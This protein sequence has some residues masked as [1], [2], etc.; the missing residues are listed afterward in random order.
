MEHSETSLILDCCS[1]LRSNRIHMMKK[2]ATCNGSFEI[3]QL[4]H[5]TEALLLPTQQ[6]PPHDL[7]DTGRR[8]A[9]QGIEHAD[10]FI[11]YSS[12]VN[13]GASGRAAAS[14]QPTRVGEG[15]AH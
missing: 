4:F 2:V 14:K 15:A 10:T 9:F 5:H 7:T 13:Y 6:L 8:V 1:M 11:I 3:L 12:G